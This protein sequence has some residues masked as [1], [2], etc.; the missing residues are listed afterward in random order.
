MLWSLLVAIF[1]VS[2][3]SQ[4]AVNVS[5][6]GYGMLKTN[7]GVDYEH[8]WGMAGDCFSARVSY[9]LFSNRNVNTQFSHIHGVNLHFSYNS[10]G[11]PSGSLKNTKRFNV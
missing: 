10:I 2:A 5:E 9:E 7:I 8:V 11:R 1:Q 6:G 4:A 3:Q